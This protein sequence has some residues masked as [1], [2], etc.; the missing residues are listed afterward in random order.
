MGRSGL[1][2]VLH[3]KV[4]RACFLFPFCF[5]FIF[6]PGKEI[7][8]IVSGI[9]KNVGELARNVNVGILG[10]WFFFC[11]ANALNVDRSWGKPCKN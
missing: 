3:R 10:F 7:S 2:V 9:C 5:S 8:E 11:N 6:Y 1:H 4:N